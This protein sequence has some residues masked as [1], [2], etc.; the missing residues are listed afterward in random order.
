[1]SLDPST[2]PPTEPSASDVRQTHAQLVR[3]LSSIRSRART[4]LLA[5]AVVSLLAVIVGTLL[6]AGT[7]D[8]VL[9]TPSWLRMS[10]WIIGVAALVLAVRRRVVP[11]A[12]FAPSLTEVALRVERSQPGREA[13]LEGV[14]A[15]GVELGDEGVT[16]ARETMRAAGLVREAGSKFSRVA[17]S[18]LLMP[19]RTLQA[20]GLFVVVIA[21]SAAIW[22]V[23]PSLASIGLRRVA[24]P[25]SGAEWPKRTQVVDAT[26]ASPHARGSGFLLRAVLTKNRTLFAAADTKADARVVGR[27]RLIVD[28]EASPPRRVL[29]T[30]QTNS[31]ANESAGAS[32]KPA[33]GEPNGDA[34]SDAT[35]GAGTRAAIA[36]NAALYEYLIEPWG[37]SPT[38]DASKAT[39]AAA[40]N[41]VEL[42]YWFET[43]DDQTRPARILLVEPPSI[44][45]ASASLTPPAYYTAVDEASPVASNPPA[46]TT[47]GSGPSPTTTPAAKT[48]DL[49]SGADE[50]ATPKPILR[51]SRVE[52]T[53][54]L[55]KPIP[56]PAAGNEKEWIARTLGPD[57]A[58]MPA[59]A[60]D[61]PGGLDVS[62]TNHTLL[63]RWTM[64]RPVRVNVNLIDEHGIG[65]VESY[66]YF[67]DALEDKPP[68]ASVT[69][70]TEDKTILP[71]ASVD[72]RGEGR[73]DVGLRSIALWQQIARPPL[74]SSGAPA[75]PV[76]DA[77]ELVKQSG[78]APTGA[79]GTAPTTTPADTGNSP[80]G[81]ASSL[82]VRL[83]VASRLDLASLNVKAGDEVWITARAIDG[84]NL[85]GATHEPAISSVRRLRII[86]EEEFI[87]QVW[88]ELTD[89]RRSAISM[90]EEQKRL[91]ADTARNAEA[92]RLERSQA[93]LSDRVA[94]E[95]QAIDDIKRRLDENGMRDEEMQSI[96]RDAQQSLEEAG[97]ASVDAASKLNQ[98]KQSEQKNGSPD[99]PSRDAAQQDQND[100]QRHLEDLAERLDQGQDTWSMKRSIEKLLEDQ[101]ALKEKTGDIG[102]Q[103]TGKQSKD[104]TP[105]ERESLEQAS[106]EQ[107][108]LA[109]RASEAIQK[110]MDAEQ[111]VRKND[112]ASADAMNQATRQAQRDQLQEKMEQASQQMQQNQTNTAQ[113]RQ[114]QAIQS[115][116][117]MLEQ[118]QNT[119]K[120]RDEVLR[121]QLASLIESLEALIVDQE[122]QIDALTEGIVKGQ[123][124]GLDRGM[125]R[126]HQNTLAVLDE[127]QE[128][129]RGSRELAPVSEL[130]DAAATAQQ[131]ATVALRVEPINADEAQDQEVV[132]LDKLKEAKAL[133]EKIDQDAQ[134]RQT[135][136]KR[137]ELKKAYTDALTQ[138]LE[139]RQEADALVGA[140]QNRRTRAEARTLG[141][142]QQVLQDTLAKLESDSKELSDAVMFSFAHKR[143][144]DSMGKA[145]SSL[146]EG[147][148]DR[149]VTRHQ[150]SA[151]KVL[152][153]L[154]AALDQ[155]KDK[156]DEFRQQQD[157]QQGSGN[158]SQNGRT[159]LVPPSAEVKLLRLMQEEALGLTREAGES[160]DS[161][162]L[163]NA[164]QLQSD[165]A[166]HAQ[167]LIKKMMERQQ[168]PG[169]GPGDGGG[170]GNKEGAEQPAGPPAPEPPPAGV[171][172]PGT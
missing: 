8:F 100:A 95:Q 9:R 142:R 166:Q 171:R 158:Q 126:L 150:D 163:D 42:E 70:P 22:A 137:A 27:F 76:E 36:P 35:P 172:T 33:A 164:G 113:T 112:P 7:A 101:K 46:S 62:L 37:L 28:G 143:L 133:A 40:P 48:L 29:L 161:S 106:Q 108:G 25:W 119:A 132:S 1:M 139:L 145:A 53:L 104:L 115:M 162:L 124:K 61:A 11:S 50:R 89:V 44:A 98:A 14:L 167:E 146:T 159:P 127:A 45:K 66:S 79:D 122:K 34:D 93:T 96:L 31:S 81:V 170:D 80:F 56:G 18:S 92:S 154:V 3:T 87:E 51:G 85:N 82:P 24:T 130:I 69:L 99:T 65:N 73:D 67:F 49:G 15:S 155:A 151:I 102:K 111:K 110:M 58:A 64:D 117:Q 54:S 74:D 121:R 52:M 38:S 5:A 26:P 43:D 120:N 32:V 60:D 84:Y 128:A 75:E 118:M 78:A 68:Q 19:G 131:Q 90:A 152:Q 116:E 86:S 91:R 160:G 55:N 23:S 103:T 6:I 13:G 2:S 147:N 72:L 135:Q 149:V 129:Q 140:E 138:Q 20:I 83:E 16:D 136:R 88:A 39:T 47:P 125:A 165:L 134:N 94:R 148:A 157:Q 21:A 153:A 105:Q 77:E 30:K 71:T 63:A 169:P 12:T 41:K 114:D 144:D 17:A 4:L 107:Q 156:D 97:K 109:Q 59:R 123:V 168:G 10:L 57:F 141:E